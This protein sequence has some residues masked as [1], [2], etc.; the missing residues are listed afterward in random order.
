MRS[1]KIIVSATVASS[2]LFKRVMDA[3]R[4]TLEELILTVEAPH[5]RNDP[6]RLLATVDAPPTLRYFFKTVLLK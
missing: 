5:A 2:K 4:P 6:K 1:L 3:Y